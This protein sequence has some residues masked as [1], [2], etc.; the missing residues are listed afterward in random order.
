MPIAVMSALALVI[1]VAVLVRMISRAG[2]PPIPTDDPEPAA[3]KPK[4]AL[5]TA[6]VLALARAGEKIAAIKLYREQTGAG[7]AEAKTAV[8]GLLEGTAPPARRPA[9][10]ADES[11][12]RRLAK[13]GQ[14]IQAIKLHREITG[15]GLAESKA[16]VERLRDGP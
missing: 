13:A 2:A 15:L 4:P 10:A 12:V 14:L 7:L 6:A 16:A 9:P 5:D 8:E 1:F 11:E 3:P